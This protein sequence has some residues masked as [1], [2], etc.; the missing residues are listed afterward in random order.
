MKLWLS[1]IDIVIPFWAYPFLIWT[2]VWKAVASWRAAR[3]GHLVWF[4]VFFIVNTIG[5]LPIVYL[6]WFQDCKKKSV[7]RTS[8]TKKVPKLFK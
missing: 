4:V 3:N 8:R 6:A 2:I 7:K 1:M 5:I